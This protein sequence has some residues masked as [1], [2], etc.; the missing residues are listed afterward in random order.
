MLDVE[1]TLAQIDDNTPITTINPREI[2]G[3][4]YLN[5]DGTAGIAT[6][7]GRE[8]AQDVVDFYHHSGKEAA[9]IWRTKLDETTL[10]EWRAA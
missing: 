4:L 3:I 9:L 8:S 7:D 1:T 2:H 10:S 5:L 6:R